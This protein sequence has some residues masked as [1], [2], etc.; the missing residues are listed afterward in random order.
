MW[1]KDG[2]SIPSLQSRHNIRNDR[3]LFICG[4]GE[5]E[6]I[7]IMKLNIDSF[8]IKL[9]IFLVNLASI[10]SIVKNLN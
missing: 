6:V 7:Q 10:I 4:K 3:F 9:Y 5:F 1:G 8:S 2:P